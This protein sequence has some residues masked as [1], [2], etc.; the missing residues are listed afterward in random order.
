MIRSSLMTLNYTVLQICMFAHFLKIN[1]KG[2]KF[3]LNMGQSR[4]LFRLFSSPPH[5]TNPLQIEKSV[6]DGM[7]GIQTRGRRM[8]GADETMELWWPPKQ[9]HK[10]EGANLFIY[11]LQILIYVCYFYFIRLSSINLDD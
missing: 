5:I 3:F 2:I 1:C 9:T 6:V 4:P 8:V 11:Y 7:L 10:V